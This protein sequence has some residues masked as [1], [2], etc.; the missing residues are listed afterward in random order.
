MNDE[1]QKLKAENAK[2]VSENAE[3]VREKAALKSGPRKQAKNELAKQTGEILKY[4]FDNPQNMTVRQIAAHF[5]I[6]PSVAHHHLDMLVAGRCITA[7]QNITELMT[8]GN[9]VG[10][11]ITPTGRAV[12]MKQAQ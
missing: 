12:V 2:L 1:M 7:K 10:Y 4:L 3:F 9:V 11:I 6:A 8:S 5:R